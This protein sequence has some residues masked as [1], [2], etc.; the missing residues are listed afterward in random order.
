MPP[1][2]NPW[3]ALAALVL[4]TVLA[5]GLAEAAVRV[6]M[7][8]WRE[9]SSARFI[10]TVAVPGQVPVMIG[11]PGFDG[12]FAQNNGDFRAHIRIN[13]AGW[14]E[15]APPEAA[16]G[17]VWVIGASMA[18]GW[19]VEAD[20]HFPA[21]I[22]RLSGRPTYNVASPGADVCGFNSLYARMPEGVRPRAVIMEL[23]LENDLRIYD[24]RAE[25]AAA[26]TAPLPADAAVPG[27]LH[28]VKLYLTERSAL[29]NFVAVAIKRAPFVVEALIGLGVVK[30]AHVSAEAELPAEAL[31]QVVDSTADEV[32][33]FAVPLLPGT[34]FAVLIAPTRFELKDGSLY[35]RRLREAMAA[36]LARR[37]VT[38]IDPVDG[39]KAAGFA[40]TH[41]RHD[42][43]WSP[44]GHRLA[45]EAALRWLAGLP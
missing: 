34:P 6:A 10:R 24:C 36:A 41:F 22:A 39:F 37:G 43:H 15:A 40:P 1:R 35:H 9:F 38:A 44:L 33:R 25:A 19:G 16:D 32:A 31:A 2:L 27:N 23:V 13:E 28:E 12:W 17:R 26:A 42:G 21:A 18:F 5:V 7:P 29:Y 20:E 30:R 45:A 8:H 14:R 3:A 4:G 11:V